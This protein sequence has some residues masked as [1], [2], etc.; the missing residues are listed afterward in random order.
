MWTGP[1]LVSELEVM[2]GLG[3]GMAPEPGLDPGHEQETAVGPELLTARG[4]GL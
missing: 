2:M 3:L 4:L 1:E